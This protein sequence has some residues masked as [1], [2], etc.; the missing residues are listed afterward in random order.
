MVRPR[1]EGKR[2][3]DAERA[4]CRPGSTPGRCAFLA[5]GRADKGP[6]NPPG[7]WYFRAESRLTAMTPN[8]M[9]SAVRRISRT[10]G[11]V[12]VR[13]TAEHDPLWNFVPLCVWGGCIDSREGWSTQLR[14]VRI[15]KIAL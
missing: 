9:D 14:I 12:G 3:E 6:Q 5:Q 13:V 8:P 1:Y 2:Q 11:P 10:S 4:G 7:G 15:F